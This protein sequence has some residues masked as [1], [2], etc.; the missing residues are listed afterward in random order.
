MAV[1]MTGGQAA[2]RV[3]YVEWLESTGAQYIDTKV[4]VPCTVEATLQGVVASSVYSVVLSAGTEEVAGR[5]FAFNSSGWSIWDNGFP[6]A[7]NEKITVTCEWNSTN[8]TA[9]I[10]GVVKSTNAT[11]TGNICVGSPWGSFPAKCK[12]YGLKI[13]CSGALV[14]D[15]WPCYDP[16]GVACLYDKVEKK[17]YYNAGTGE[18]I[19]G[20]AAA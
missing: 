14:R 9:T 10:N 20:G 17:Y 7:Y 1:F 5:W 18:F 11:I 4:G 6:T 13:Y 2:D 19:A 12:I 3:N 8:L 16:S 15:L